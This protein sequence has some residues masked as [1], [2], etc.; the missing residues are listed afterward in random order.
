MEKEP[1]PLTSP[2][3]PLILITVSGKDHPGITSAMTAVLAHHQAVILDVGQSVIR[4]LLSLSILFQPGGQEKST[5]TKLTDDLIKKAEDLGLQLQTKHMDPVDLKQAQKAHLTSSAHRYALTL[6]GSP[7]SAQAV[8]EVTETLAKDRLNIDQI[9]RL[10]DGEFSCVEFLLSTSE[11]VNSKALKERLLKTAQ[12][13]G[14]DISFQAEGLFRRAKRLI[15]LDMDSTLIQNEVIDEFAR[16]KGVYEQVAA[17]TEKAMQGELDFNESLKKRCALLQG[18]NE[19]DIESVYQNIKLTPG[20]EELCYVLK[21]LGY[22]IAIISGG[23]LKVADRL[24]T[25]LGLDFAYANRM[26]FKD[27]VFTGSIQAPYLNAQRKADLLDVISQQENIELDQVIAIGD[28]AND[29]LML[30]KAGLGIAFN[31]KPVVSAQA[32]FSLNQKNLRNIFYLLGLSGRDV[33]E[34]LASS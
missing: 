31:A 20:A 18:I 28:G 21:R 13:L 27:G 23:F 25:K 7:I 5:Q 33:K 16:Q 24:K 22:K 4:G 8:H 3:A 26:I 17:I 1:H 6:L 19:K 10:S 9:Q 12:S 30:K 29:L 32:D 34:I 14:V 15:V 2:V 11:S